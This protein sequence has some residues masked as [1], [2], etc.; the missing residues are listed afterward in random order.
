VGLRVAS[1]LGTYWHRRLARSEAVYYLKLALEHDRDGQPAALRAEVLRYFGSMIQESDKA[2]SAQIY[3][4]S[5]KMFR[6]LG[7]PIGAAKVLRDM[8][9]YQFF[10]GN[11]AKSKELYEEALANARIGN[12]RKAIGLCTGGLS[13]VVAPLGDYRRAA[14]LCAEC[15]SIFREINDA[16]CMAW[17][18]RTMGLLQFDLGDFKS[19]KRCNEE[20]LDI[21]RSSNARQGIAWCLVD[22][23]SAATE[24]GQPNIGEELIQEGLQIFRELNDHMAAA[25]AMET[26]V[27]N[28]VVLGRADEAESL[29]KE[30]LSVYLS[31]NHDLGIARVLDCLGDLEAEPAAAEDRYREGLTLWQKVGDVKSIRLSLLRLGATAFARG[32]VSRSAKLGARSVHLGEQIGLSLP[33]CLQG[34]SGYLALV[35][36]SHPSEW[37][38][39]M[40]LETSCAV[41]L[42]FDA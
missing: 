18:L 36:A 21:F 22:L 1:A 14:E 31:S 27:R 24:S 37:E 38:L 11:L 2:L 26:L 19:M 25:S 6:Q 17:S 39:G 40:Q 23:G 20:A 7:D 34:K 3:D 42:A 8:G 32:D 30:S 15:I 29:L 12:D 16:Y 41:E 35:Q 10:D 5:L 28:S 4:E 9:L 33:P 13:T